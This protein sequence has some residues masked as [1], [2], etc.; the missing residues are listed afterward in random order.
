MLIVGHMRSGSTL[1]LHLLMT[2]SEV[3]SCG[4]RNAVYR[5]PRDLD[6]LAV[7][8]AIAQRRRF[9]GSRYA[10]DQVNHDHLTPDPRLLLASRVR[11]IFLVR[12]PRAAIDSIIRLT[13]GFYEPWPLAR[14]VDY[15]SRRLASMAA[16]AR[17]LHGHRPFLA[18]TYDQLIDETPGS[19]R[20]IESFLDLGN[21]LGEHYGLHGFTG[22][23]GD[24]GEAIR[25]GR[26]QRH[27]RPVPSE[28]SARELE[29][30]VGAYSSCLEALQHGR[31]Y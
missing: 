31:R 17:M 6:D 19:L 13:T 5:R 16:I 30:T 28:M 7:S 15:Y 1:L 10:V 24:P 14:A 12:E 29:R 23:R 2:S 18:L 8:A 9:R 26:I 21:S 25:S 4:E 3:I 20:R 22:S 27:R 11:C